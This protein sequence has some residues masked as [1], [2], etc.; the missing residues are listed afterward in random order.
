SVWPFRRRESRAIHLNMPT[1]APHEYLPEVRFWKK[2]DTLRFHSRAGGYYWGRLIRVTSDGWVFLD[3]GIGRPKIK[4]VHVRHI[5]PGSNET[6]TTR[7]L[8]EELA[9]LD[10]DYQEFCEAYQQAHREVTV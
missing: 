7:A 6:Y 10:D 5:P 1:L 2:S 4:K 8:T 9:G 3:E